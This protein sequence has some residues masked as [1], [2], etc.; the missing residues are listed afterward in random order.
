MKTYPPKEKLWDLF[1]YRDG[2]LFRRKRIKGVRPGPVTG[3][4][5]HGR[6]RVQIDRVGYYVHRLIWIMH[7]GYI[8]ADKLI[9]HINGNPVD[10]RIENLRLV[11]AR[12]NQFNRRKRT[13]KNS[14][15][16]PYKGVTFCPADGKYHVIIQKDYKSM[17]AG[18]FESERDAALA[19]NRRALELFG[20]HACLNEVD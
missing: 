2:V 4:T 15:S 13:L 17:R 18:R 11:T 12:Q 19:Y 9:D 14:L 20:E 7:F 10:N 8:P 1:D 3:T 5:V 16:S 6:V